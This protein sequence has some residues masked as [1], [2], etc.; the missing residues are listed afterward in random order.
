VD[1]GVTG[2]KILGKISA[3]APCGRRQA[4]AQSDDDMENGAQFP[5]VSVPFMAR[6]LYFVRRS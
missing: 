3:F 1:I 4:E 6:L 2:L 5:H